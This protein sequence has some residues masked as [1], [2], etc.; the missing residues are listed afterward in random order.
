MKKKVLLLGGTGRIGPGIVE[1]YL[2]NYKSFYDLVIGYHSKKPKY[3]G[4]KFA[5]VDLSRI[6]ILKRAMKGVYAVVNLAANSD[7]NEKDFDKIL[8]PNIIG[9]YNVFEAARSAKVKRVVFASSVHAIKGYPHGR[10]ISFKNNPLPLNLYGASKVFGE[11]LCKVF[12]TQY[13]ISCLAIRIGAYVANNKKNTI[14]STRTDYDYTISQRD[15]AQLIHKSI[16]APLSIK[17][18][19]LSGTSNNKHNKMELKY[20][21]KLINYTPI[22]DHFDIC[23]G[24]KKKFK[25]KKK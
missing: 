7:P 19:I 6:N 14:C 12:C 5:K 15:L 17:Y 20:T 3:K 13:D 23:K 25:I 9:A 18:A 21:K 24:I 1:E 2:N 10:I 4:L 22:D 16:I 11:S 8:K